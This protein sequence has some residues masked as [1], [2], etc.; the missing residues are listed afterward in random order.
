LIPSAGLTSITRLDVVGTDGV[1]EFVFGL[2]FISGYVEWWIYDPC[3]SGGDYG[4]GYLYTFC[5]RPP[6]GVGDPP[7][8]IPPVF[9]LQPAIDGLTQPFLVDGGLVIFLSGSN[10][11]DNDGTGST[12]ARNGDTANGADGVTFHLFLDAAMA[13]QFNHGC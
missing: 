5:T 6:C 12:P 8:G 10:D 1:P 3:K 13:G 11:L 4:D 7:L 9:H 2:P